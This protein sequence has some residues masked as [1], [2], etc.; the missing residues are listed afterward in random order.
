MEKIFNLTVICPQCHSGRGMFC[1]PHPWWVTCSPLL[2][3]HDPNP[4]AKGWEGSDWDWTER[5]A[6]K[7]AP[8]TT[9]A[10]LAVNKTVLSCN[11]W[12]NL[13]SLNGNISNNTLLLLIQMCLLALISPIIKMM[14]PALQ[15]DPGNVGLPGLKG[16]KVGNTKGSRKEPS[17]PQ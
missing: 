1:M 17:W 4:A 13:F 16:D 10:S 14:S 11:C 7:C 8:V 3:C 12:K 9:N 5:R 15:G 6:S 2:R